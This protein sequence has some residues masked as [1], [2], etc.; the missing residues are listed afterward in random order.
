MKFKNLK[1][2]RVYDLRDGVVV[3]GFCNHRACKDCPIYNKDTGKSCVGKIYETPYEVARKM[4]YKVLEQGYVI[5][6]RV[7]D[8][9][10]DTA[11]ERL[12]TSG[13]YELGIQ[14]TGKRF[15]IDDGQVKIVT[16]K[17]KRQGEVKTL[18]AL[19]AI[20]P[21]PG[22]EK[23]REA[24]KSDSPPGFLVS[25]LVKS[26]IC[27]ICEKEFFTGKCHHVV[28]QEYDGKTCVRILSGVTEILDWGFGS[29]TAGKYREEKEKTIGEGKKDGKS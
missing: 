3:S 29:W 2:E 16:T 18:Y 23:L 15:I 5:W 1:T 7:C 13:L 6:V 14:L 25:Y 21:T 22:T 4:G 12:S 20:E 27:S 19:V 26:Q 9:Q 8:D 11:G 10:V 17:V 28:G 24:L